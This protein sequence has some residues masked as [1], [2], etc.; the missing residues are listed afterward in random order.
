MDKAIQIAYNELFELKCRLAGEAGFRHIAV[1]YTEILGK[2]DSEWKRITEN[3]QQILDRYGLKCVQTHP[4][5]YDLL[6]SSEI[7]DEEM[8]KNIRRSIASSSAIGAEYCVIHP[9]TSVSTGYRVSVSFED[10]KRWLSELIDCAVTHG[11]KIAVENLPIFPSDKGAMPFYSS[12]F[13]DLGILVDYFNVPDMAICWDF[14]HANMMIWDQAVAIRHL[15]GRIRCTHVHN[16]FAIKDSHSTPDE[17]NIDWSR[18]MAAVR[19]IGYSGP[20]TLETHCR[21]VEEGMLRSFARHNFGCLEYLERVIE[22]SK[23]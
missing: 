22:G 19:D 13:E 23:E 5:Y 9:R 4:H 2:S 3:I 17:G 14:G 15:A 1:N 8:E 18:V 20:L 21:Y 12:G 11:T 7:R 6:L 10:N 16:N